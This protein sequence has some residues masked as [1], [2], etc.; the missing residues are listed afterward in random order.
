MAER[1]KVP[2]VI[3]VGGWGDGLA[4]H[5]GAQDHEASGMYREQI[6]F[7]AVTSSEGRISSGGGGVV[8]KRKGGTYLF[9]YYRKCPSM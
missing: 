7:S 4:G 5:E 9:I 3:V 8:N 6:I 1:I 2:M